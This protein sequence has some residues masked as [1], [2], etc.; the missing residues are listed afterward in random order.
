MSHPDNPSAAP[1][2]NLGIDAARWQSWLNRIVGSLS[3]RTRIIAIA[4]IPIVGLSFTG[5]IFRTGE[6]EIEAVFDT[7]LKAADLTEVSADYQRALS[8]IRM[9]VRD[10][11]SR[12]SEEQVW[13]FGET[14]Y[15][16]L[17]RLEWIGKSLKTSDDHSAEAAIK[18]LDAQ[19]ARLN[20]VGANFKNII[21]EQR[22]LGFT[23][24]EGIRRRLREASSAVELIINKDILGASKS[25]AQNLTAELLVMRRYEAEYRINRSEFIRQSFFAEFEEFKTHL[26]ELDAAGDTK[27]ELLAK[28]TEYTEVFSSW[29]DGTD[30]VLP[31]V[32]VIDVDTQQMIPMADKLIAFARVQ[33]LK[34]NAV[35]KSLQ[36]RTR[37]TII[38][39]G[40]AAVMIGLALSWLIGRSITG[41]LKGLAA[42][43]KKLAAGDTSARIPATRSRDEIGDMARTVI[44]FRDTMI[45]RESLA[46][47]QNETGRERE[48][49]SEV[50]AATIM[51]FEKSVDQVLRK[52]RAAAERME[53]TSGELNGAA[54]SMAAE[55]RQAEN[56]VNAAS[57]DVTA[58]AGSVEELAASIGEIS[59]QAHTSTDV[60]GRVV[61]EARRT[62]QTMTDLGI[63]ATRIGEVVSLIQ[64][65]AGQ[66]NLLALN[67][68]IEAARAGEAGRGFAVVAS[69]VKS[70]AGQTAKATEDIASQVGAIQSAAADAAQAID[71]VNTTIEDMSAI[72]AS[73]AATVEEQNSAVMSIAEGMTS[74]STEA[75]TGA[76]A[77]SRVASATKDARATAE[78]VRSV[79]DALALEAEGLE[80]EVRR[81]LAEV[82][83]A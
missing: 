16:A 78:E 7:T 19:R 50:I 40:F 53:A 83:A 45:E 11:A 2:R 10:F 56:R 8:A 12:P 41:P 67:A 68:T 3:V 55:A 28:V 64:A 79:A 27:N 13:E 24:N 47:T 69:E 59:H 30:N 31:F 72:A 4:L 81:F 77:M 71:K 65:I 48:R 73:V 82:R 9:L 80:G 76:E 74:A 6:S 51:R 18:D 63:A 26:A 61:A 23:D 38:A 49:R 62:A 46:A 25:K 57:T 37:N 75:R 58:A 17:D 52:L 36:A 5:W 1:F 29:I 54:N 34:S 14:H 66:T 20:D 33:A 42:V 32:T 70:L 60:A 15:R 22:R 39:V 35:L 44:V 43:M 21:G